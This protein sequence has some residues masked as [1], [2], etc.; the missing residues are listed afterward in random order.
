GFAYSTN[1]YKQPGIKANQMYIS[2][3]AGYRNKG[4]FIDLTY[5]QGFSQDVNFPYRLSDKANT[6]A[7][8]K[9]FN[10]TIL[11]TVGFKFL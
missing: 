7:T 2:G 4:M 6:F 5:V 8:I 3:G 9:Q 10:G 1:P 11:V